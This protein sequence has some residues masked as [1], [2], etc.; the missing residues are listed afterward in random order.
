MCTVHGVDDVKG[1]SHFPLCRLSSR[2]LCLDHAGVDKS[3]MLL[4]RMVLTTQTQKLQHPNTKATNKQGWGSC[5]KPWHYKK[6]SH[7]RTCRSH[8]STFLAPGGAVPCAPAT[9][10]RAF[11]PRSAR[12]GR[13]TAELKWVVAAKACGD[14]GSSAASNQK[15]EPAMSAVCILHSPAACG[16]PPQPPTPRVKAQRRDMYTCDITTRRHVSHRC[17]TCS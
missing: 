4:L 16:G 1:S 8:T 10:A 9:R 17:W 6:S 7:Q 5:A 14:G 15:N 2:A 11:F 12:A 3:Q 13:D